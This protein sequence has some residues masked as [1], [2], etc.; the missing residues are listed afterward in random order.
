[1]THSAAQFPE[2]GNNPSRQQLPDLIYNNGDYS[3]L[4][5][6]SVR[7]ILRELRTLRKD[8][9]YRIGRTVDK[10]TVRVALLM[11]DTVFERL[12]NKH[13]F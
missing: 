3:P 7:K 11:A 13:D 9:D 6:R 12:E 10:Q 5:R 2:S 8:A 1:M 4:T